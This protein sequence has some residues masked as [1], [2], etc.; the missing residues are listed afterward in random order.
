MGGCAARAHRK[1]QRCRPI[2]EG[3][4]LPTGPFAL[5]APAPQRLPMGEGHNAACSCTH[6]PRSSQGRHEPLGSIPMP[7]I[8]HCR[9]RLQR[10][11]WA[12]VR[13]ECFRAMRAMRC[14]ARELVNARRAATHRVNQIRIQPSQ[15]NVLRSAHP[16]TI[17]IEI[18][19]E[20]KPTAD[21]L[22]SSSASRFASS[23][24]AACRSTARPFEASRDRRYQSR[25]RRF[26]RAAKSPS[27][28]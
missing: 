21:P 7:S 15:R 5:A 9:S 14:C 13:G 3:H 23:S 10:C 26:P 11:W 20:L 22:G 28:R 12:A 4:R 1:G 24:C 17:L 25:C 8:M 19:Y 18:R 6:R 2:T 16:P 27:R